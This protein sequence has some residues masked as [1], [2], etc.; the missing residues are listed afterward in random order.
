LFDPSREQ[1]SLVQAGDAVRF[2]PIS[3][4]EF[5]E[6]HSHEFTR[7]PQICDV[8]EQD[9]GECDVLEPGLLT[10][11]QVDGYDVP[12]WTAIL[13]RAGS[14]LSMAGSTGAGSRAWLCVAGGIDVPDVLG[15][16]STLLRAALGGFE[17]RALRTG[18][19]LRLRPLTREAKHLDG[20]SCPVALRPSYAM[21][22][23]VPVLPGPQADALTPGG[24][25]AFADATWTVSNDS[26]RMGRWLEGPRPDLEGSA[27]VIS[28]VV[29][30]GAVEVTGSG[31]PIIMLAD[32][33]T[34]GGY[35]KPFILALVGH[36][37]GWRSVNRV[38]ASA[39]ACAPSMTHGTCRRG[40]PVQGGN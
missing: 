11:V 9:V 34:T 12:A 28:E 22:T 20:F 10:T 16:R 17:G 7:Y 39:F 4:E 15:S 23:P 29:P 36:S 26:Y 32:R 35:V 13:V 18:D 33:Q 31:L 5:E 38:T 27:D 24:R 2:S 40:N 25:Q 21:D 14:V 37:D 19:R 3:V 6:Q 30:E 8:S 1:P